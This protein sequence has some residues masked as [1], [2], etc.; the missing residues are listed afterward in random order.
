MKV[1]CS[2]THLIGGLCLSVCLSVCLSICLSSSCTLLQLRVTPARIVKSMH[3]ASKQASKQTQRQLVWFDCC[4]M[5]SH[6]Y[7]GFFLKK[8]IFVGLI[9]IS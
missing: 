5:W 4:G 3:Q 1:T 8:D 7:G 2:L 9:N 6:H